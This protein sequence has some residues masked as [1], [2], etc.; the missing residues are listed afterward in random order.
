LTTEFLLTELQIERLTTLPQYINQNHIQ[1]VNH[2]GTFFHLNPDL[3][4]DVNRIVLCHV[5]A[6]NPMTKDQESIAA[7]N[8]Y[9]QLG[10]LKPLNGTTQNACVPVQLYNIN[11]QIRGN[12]STNHCIAFPM[13][14]PVECLKKLPFVDEKYCPQV[15]FLGPRDEWMKK[16]GKYKYLYEMDTEI[17]YDWLRVWV[18]ANHPSFQNCIIDT[19]DNVRDGMNLVTEKIIEEAITKTDP[20]IIGI[21]SMLDAKDE[22]NSEGMC[23]IDHE[24]A[25]PYTIHTAVLPKPSFIDANVNSAFMAM[26]DIFQ[27][28]NDDVDEDETYDEVLPHENYV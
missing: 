20:D 4:F 21:S 1:V 9:G 22:E 25:S 3:V 11:L 27:P 7:G 14:G 5:C 23:N 13:N 16:T 2:N 18:D 17:A 24:S 10:S 26:L 15:T 8:D 6:K 19:S 12:H 28:K